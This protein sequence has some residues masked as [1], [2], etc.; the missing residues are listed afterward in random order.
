MEDVI[1]LW[2]EENV[3][4]GTMQEW[5]ADYAEKYAVPDFVD[6]LRMDEFWE[7]L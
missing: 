2:L 5:E 3:D 4:A 7:G 1:S 6:K